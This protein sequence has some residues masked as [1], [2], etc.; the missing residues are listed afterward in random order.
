MRRVE[1]GW[2]ESNSHLDEIRADNKLS[3]LSDKV[4]RRTIIT[5]LGKNTD[6]CSREV[7]VLMKEFPDIANSPARVV[8]VGGGFGNFCKVLSDRIDIERYV[9]VD[10]PSMLKFAKKFHEV[11]NVPCEYM[12]VDEIDNLV[13]QEF[14]IFVSNICLSETPKEYR[15]RLLNNVLPT[16]QRLYVIN[17]DQR[18]HPELDGGKFNEELE[19][20]FSRHFDHLQVT[21]MEHSVCCQRYC[22]L[23]IAKSI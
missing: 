10:T 18:A 11:F 3:F 15:E 17:G 1:K 12:T 14:D 6:M 4:I 7:D 5:P 21:P 20:L 19:E 13:G 9:I 23:Y 16:C 8:E 22:N 2:E